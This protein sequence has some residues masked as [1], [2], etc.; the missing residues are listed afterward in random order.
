[1]KTFQVEASNNCIRSCIIWLDWPQNRIKSCLFHYV[2]LRWYKR[3]YNLSRYTKPFSGTP[4]FERRARWLP[5][6]ECLGRVITIAEFIYT[7]ICLLCKTSVGQARGV[8]LLFILRTS[9]CELKEDEDI[10]CCLH[11][12]NGIGLKDILEWCKC[13]AWYSTPIAQ[14]TCYPHWKARVMPTVSLAIAKLLTL[15]TTNKLGIH[16]NKLKP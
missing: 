13:C 1:M 14:R 2:G 15:N 11:G 4:N 5:A 8:H 10:R 12:R 6:Y 16:I 3:L 7:W 9:A